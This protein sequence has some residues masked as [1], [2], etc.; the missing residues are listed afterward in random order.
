MNGATGQSLSVII[1]WENTLNA[2]SSR[3]THMLESLG[4]QLQALNQPRV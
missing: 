4:K 1:E 3:T 2:E